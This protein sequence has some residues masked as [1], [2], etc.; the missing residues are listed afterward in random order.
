M[1]PKIALSFQQEYASD[2]YPGSH[3]SSP[4]LPTLVS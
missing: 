3:E 4:Q 1:E 2:T